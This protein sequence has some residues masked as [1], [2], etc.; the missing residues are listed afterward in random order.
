MGDAIPGWSA[1][2]SMCDGWYLDRSGCELRCDGQVLESSFIGAAQGE[3]EPAGGASALWADD[4]APLAAVI[5]PAH[6][7]DRY[8]VTP[9]RGEA[10]V[11]STCVGV[12]TGRLYRYR[13]LLIGTAYVH[14]RRIPR[15]GMSSRGNAG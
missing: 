7:R 14:R 1:T 3:S 6:R 13:G 11:T 12:E 15:R 5:P 9:Q 4:Q 8:S 2:W 10:T